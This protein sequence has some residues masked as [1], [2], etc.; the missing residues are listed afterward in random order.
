MVKKKFKESLE[1]AKA[2]ESE[3]KELRN[4]HEI[5]KDEDKFEEEEKIL[6]KSI[7]KLYN[8]KKKNKKQK[9]KKK[10]NK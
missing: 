9:T 8:T 4:L 10:R 1:K 3:E 7:G 6:K 5:E 2:L